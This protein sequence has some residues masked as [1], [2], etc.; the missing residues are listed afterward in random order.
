[1]S[2]TDISSKPL[3]VPLIAAEQVASNIVR[4]MLSGHGETICLPIVGQVRY[5]YYYRYDYVY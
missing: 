5:Q 1:M 2:I 4:R 3:R